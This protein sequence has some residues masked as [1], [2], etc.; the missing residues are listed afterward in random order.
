[1]LWYI[2]I[3]MLHNAAIRDATDNTIMAVRRDRVLQQTRHYNSVQW[4][5]GGRSRVEK[6]EV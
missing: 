2:V 1:M 6:T 3:F 4:S 5:R